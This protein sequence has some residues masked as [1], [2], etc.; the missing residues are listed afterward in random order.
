MH[1]RERF[2]TNTRSFTSSPIIG[3]LIMFLNA[4]TGSFEGGNSSA[5]LIFANPTAGSINCLNTAGTSTPV[6]INVGLLITNTNLEQGNQL[7]N[8]TS[9]ATESA[10]YDLTSTPTGDRIIISLPS[11]GKLEVRSNKINNPVIAKLLPKTGEFCPTRLSLSPNAQRIAVLDDPDAPKDPNNPN[12]PERICTNT[13][14]RPPRVLVFDL[15]AISAS[16]T[17]L[18]PIRVAT[19]GLSGTFQTDRAGGPLALTQN[20]TQ[21]FVIAPITSYAIFKLNKDN[22]AR[23]NPQ[24]LKLAGLQTL[25]KTLRLDLT[26]IG[27]RL[28]FTFSSNSG[29]GGGAYFVTINP[30]TL[31]LEPVALNSKPLTA[32]T[33][34][35]WNKRPNDSLIA[36]LQPN[37]VVFQRISTPA[38]NSKAIPISNPIDAAFTT[39]GYAWMLQTN[40]VSRFD[41]TNL[42]T[43]N[44]ANQ[45]YLGGLN[46]RAIGTFIQQ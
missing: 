12:A 39:D 17:T 18:E 26:N 8:C 37:Q 40:S 6:P 38:S 23:V 13:S 16:N 41:V 21:A 45:V 43:I 32:T 15:S 33:R 30:N 3:T 11:S 7:S 27:T 24:E 10:P 19:G 5:R 25:D 22:D 34:A 44:N 42:S 14:N 35:I 1:A 28:L 46:P 20:D 29:A 9:V 31:S 4:C 36:Y 2:N